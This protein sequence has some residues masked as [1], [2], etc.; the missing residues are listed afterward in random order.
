MDR[1]EAILHGT[2]HGRG[3]YASG[4][5]YAP[6]LMVEQT[7]ALIELQRHFIEGGQ[8]MESSEPLKFT[9]E[10]EQRLAALSS[11]HKEGP[12][13]EVSV[14]LHITVS[15]PV[16]YTPEQVANQLEFD[17]LADPYIREAMRV[18]DS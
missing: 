7:S 15:V 10:E 13:K 11:F 16:T 6:Q 17:L 18:L 9:E 14:T 5:R 3:R 4:N 2:S 12:R 8:E 1:E